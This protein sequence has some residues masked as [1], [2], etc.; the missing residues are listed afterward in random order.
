[1]IL[2]GLMG[3]MQGRVSPEVPASFG[4]LA[5]GAHQ[6]SSKNKA[7]NGLFASDTSPLEIC[8]GIKQCKVRAAVAHRRVLIGQVL[9][10]QDQRTTAKL[11][12]KVKPARRVLRYTPMLTKANMT[13]ARR[14]LRGSQPG[15]PLANTQRCCP[16]PDPPDLKR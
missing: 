14:S 4:H 12:S 13:T 1:M 9:E 5:E 7:H 10:H 3:S 15:I 11:S 8:R 16:D 6:K 2:S